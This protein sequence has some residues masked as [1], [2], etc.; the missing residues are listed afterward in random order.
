MIK[1]S[2]GK[3]EIIGKKADVT[4]DLACIIDTLIKNIGK[5]ETKEIIKIAYEIIEDEKIEEN[6]TE[7][8]KKMIKEKLPKEISKILLELI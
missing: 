2:R 4:A 5:Y 6:C 1:S 3:V 8:L 7:E